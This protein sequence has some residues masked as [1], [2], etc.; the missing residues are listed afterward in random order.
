MKSK[1]IVGI[2]GSPNKDGRTHQL[3]AAALDGATAAGAQTELIQMSEHVV[4]ACKDCLPWVCKDNLKCTYEDSAFDY[5]REKVLNAGGLVF[6]SPVYWSDTSAM[7]KFFILKM[8][9]LYA[10]S[11]PLNGLP[12]LGLAIAGGTG[13]GLISGLRPLYHFFQIM[14]MRAIAS[15]PA[16]RFNFE[17][18]LKQARTQGMEI[19]AMSEKSAPF[20]RREKVLAHYDQLP[21]L[22]LDRSEERRLLAALVATAAAEKNDPAALLSLAK[23]DLL[24]AG[25][26]KLAALDEIAVAYEGGLKTIDK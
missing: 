22:G 2:V 16:T 9:R 23:A 7:V 18:A 20:K 17:F 12:A 13:N 21:Y 19:G 24:T 25:N 26:Q 5:L 15:V 4:D 1:T 14:Q 8:F 10:M 6:G 3:V 11:G